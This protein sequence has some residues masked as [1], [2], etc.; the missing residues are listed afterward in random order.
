MI[1]ENN[2]L[3]GFFKVLYELFAAFLEMGDSPIQPID[4]ASGIAYFFIIAGGG[5]IVGILFAFLAAIL[6]KLV[7]N[8]S[9]KIYQNNFRS[10]SDYIKNRLNFISESK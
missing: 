2:D 4:Y 8:H 10:E 3:S 7:K 5:A 9:H 1:Q 6:T